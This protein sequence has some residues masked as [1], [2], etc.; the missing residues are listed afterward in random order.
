MA[1]IPLPT[2]DSLD[3]LQ[4]QVYNKVVSSPRG[5]S[6]GPLRAALYNPS[7]AEY[8]WQAFGAQLRYHTQ[9]PRELSELADCPR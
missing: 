1:R 5:T 9:L 4:Q 7:L 6:R 8:F 3:A 2:P